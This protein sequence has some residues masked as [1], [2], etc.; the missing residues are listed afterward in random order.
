[1][2]DPLKCPEEDAGG[3][4]LGTQHGARHFLGPSFLF[5]STVV[6]VALVCVFSVSSQRNRLDLGRRGRWGL[7]SPTL[8]AKLRLAAPRICSDLEQFGLRLSPEDLPELDR[9]DSAINFAP[10]QK[11]EIQTHAFLVP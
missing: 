9:A 6:D 5:G 11:R 4:A 3:G 2:V 1:M 7:L 8:N 10:S